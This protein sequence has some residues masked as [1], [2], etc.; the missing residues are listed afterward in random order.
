MTE[1]PEEV[2]K[3]RKI[4][5]DL[6]RGSWPNFVKEAQKTRYPVDL[7]GASLA[8]KRDLFT[9]GGYVSV[10]G[11]PTG[12]LMRVTSRPDIGESANIVRILIPSGNFVTSDM[13]DK[14]CELADKYGVGLIH[15]I[16]TGEDI[17]IPGIPKER[18]RDFIA[19]LRQNGYE[20]GSTGDAFRATTTCVGS[21]LCEYSNLNTEE[22]RDKFYDIYNDLAKYPTFPHK[23]KVKV[24]GCPIDCG[25]AT[26]KADIGIIG[27]WKGAPEIDENLM[28]NLSEAEIN[29]IVSGCPTSAISREGNKIKIKAEDCNQCMLCVRKSKGAIMPGK[30]KQYLVYIGGKLRGKKGPLTGKLLTRLNTPE[31]ALNIINRIVEVYI[32]HAARK[33]RIGDMLLRVG[34]KGFIDMLKEKPKAMNSKDLRTNVFYAVD[35]KGREEIPKE[36]SKAVGGD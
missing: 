22:F 19:E 4:L 13:L 27:S 26:Q 20:C 23:V 35:E 28:K 30:E 36:V 9:T 2:V 16:S 17:E 15:A 6:K 11:A 10:P 32:Y 33:E 3:G 12:I 21:A 5:E 29:E 31:E 18:I 34:M 1:L 25:R 14:L 24:S 8:L 7:Y